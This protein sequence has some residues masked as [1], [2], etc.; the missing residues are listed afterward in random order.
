MPEATVT[1]MFQPD[2][3]DVLRIVRRCEDF[4]VAFDSLQSRF[5]GGYVSLADGTI[6]SVHPADVIALSIRGIHRNPEDPE[7]IDVVGI[8]DL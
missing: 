7:A 3:S 8:F 1:L 6:T 2:A 4:S 5:D